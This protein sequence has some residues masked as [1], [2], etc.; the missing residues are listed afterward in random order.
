MLL[1]KS[2]KSNKSPGG[3]IGGFP[4]FGTLMFLEFSD[5][6]SNPLIVVIL[7]QKVDFE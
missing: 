3:F 7:F 5:S 1:P 4:V 2:S 6:A